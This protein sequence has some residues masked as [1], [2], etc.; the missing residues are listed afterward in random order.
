[1]SN[2]SRNRKSGHYNIKKV[3]KNIKSIKIIKENITKQM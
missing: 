2:K 3:K 1:M